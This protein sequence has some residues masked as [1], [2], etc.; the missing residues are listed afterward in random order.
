MRARGPGPPPEFAASIM[1]FVGA[2]ERR[3]Y[4]RQPTTAA[5]EAVY[6]A[7]RSDLMLGASDVAAPCVDG[8]KSKASRTP[9]PLTRPPQAANDVLVRRSA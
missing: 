8:D 7:Y 9:P 1:P 3:G 2:L 5:C 6:S 4:S